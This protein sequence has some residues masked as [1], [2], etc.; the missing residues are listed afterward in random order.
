[1]YLL[2]LGPLLRN[3][4]RNVTGV[5]A[6]H[7]ISTPTW[8]WKEAPQVDAPPSSCQGP[9]LSLGGNEVSDRC[10]LN[11]GLSGKSG[12][13]GTQQTESRESWGFKRKGKGGRNESKE[14]ERR[15]VEERWVK[16]GQEAATWKA[17]RR[18]QQRKMERCPVSD[19]NA[20]AL[21]GHS[22]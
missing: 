3:Q 11:K 10:G 5:L 20:Q 18:Q 19:Q 22:R 13:P 6:H 14:K 1:M 7:P 16:K 4:Y 8:N 15:R 17:L 12:T 9:G 2:R 21:V